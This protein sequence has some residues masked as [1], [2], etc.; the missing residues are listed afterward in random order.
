MQAQVVMRIGWTVGVEPLD[1]AAVRARP[2]GAV[3]VPL[4][5]CQLCIPSRC[6]KSL[7]IDMGTSHGT[8][9]WPGDR[10]A[11]DLRLGLLFAMWNKQ[12]A[13]V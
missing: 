2:V 5:T 7:I 8:V 11:G 6:A 10:R 1:L 4:G 9:V 13:A 12:T 3:V